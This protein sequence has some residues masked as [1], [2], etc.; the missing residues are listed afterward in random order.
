MQTPAWCVHYV[1]NY[2]KEHL[3]NDCKKKASKYYVWVKVLWVISLFL[4]F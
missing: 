1:H 4:I 3:E 2:G